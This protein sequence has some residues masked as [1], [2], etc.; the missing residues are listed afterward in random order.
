MI[1]LKRL[2]QMYSVYETDLTVRT[3]IEELPL[4]LEFPIAARISEFVAQVEELMGC[5]MH[6][7]MRPMVMQSLTYG[8]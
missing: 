1:F 8:S 5:I 4:L 6:Q 2:E 3:E 7:F